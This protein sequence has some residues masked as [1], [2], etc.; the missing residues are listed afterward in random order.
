MSSINLFKD[1]DPL[2][3]QS[4]FFKSNSFNGQTFY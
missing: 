3:I 4:K 2:P 1:V